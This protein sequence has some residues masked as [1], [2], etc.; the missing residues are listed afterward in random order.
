MTLHKSIRGL[1]S[2]IK[3][4]HWLVEFMAQNF[5]N[6]VAVSVL[7]KLKPGDVLLLPLGSLIKHFRLSLLTHN[8]YQACIM[9]NI[10]SYNQLYANLHCF[11]DF[12]DGL[13]L[14][15][16]VV[17]SPLE[18]IS[19]FEKIGVASPLSYMKFLNSD[20][21]KFKEKYSGIY[22]NFLRMLNGKGLNTLE[23]ANQLALNRIKKTWQGGGTIHLVKATDNELVDFF[24]DKAEVHQ[25]KINALAEHTILECENIFEESSVITFHIREQLENSPAK[26]YVVSEDAKVTQLIENKLARLNITTRGY[27]RNLSDTSPYALLKAIIDYGD[28]FKFRLV[29]LL[30]AYISRFKNVAA[31]SELEDRY[32]RKPYEI[33]SFAELLSIIGDHGL[34]LELIKLAELFSVIEEA[35]TFKDFTIGVFEVFNYLAAFELI[36]SAEADAL[37]QLKDKVLDAKFS[38]A[39]K[40]QFK[41]VLELLAKSQIITVP[42]I[43]EPN[44]E[45]I[46]FEQLAFYNPEVLV[47]AGSNTELIKEEAHKELLNSFANCLLTYAKFTTDEEKDPALFYPINNESKYH[48]WLMQLSSEP[49]SPSNR[50]EPDCALRPTKYS[51]SSVEQL[52][53]D[54][55]VFYAKY[56]LKL[57]E[58][59]EINLKPER[60]EFGLAMHYALSKLTMSEQ[61]DEQ[62]F[63]A[64]IAAEFNTFLAETHIKPKPYWEQKMLRIANELYK[65][66]VEN[67]CIEFVTEAYGEKALSIFDQPVVLNMR[68]DRIDN[69]VDGTKIIYD[70][71]TG[72]APTNVL[73]KSGKKPQLL[74]GAYVFGFTSTKLSYLSLLGKKEVVCPTNMRFELKSVEEGLNQLFTT[75]M[76]SKYYAQLHFDE[77]IPWA[78]RH[79]NRY[80]EWYS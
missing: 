61:N 34:R 75:Y 67:P 2:A 64:K 21:E 6:S 45:F 78:Y 74:I 37:V 16:I 32:L 27:T 11:C 41:R 19:C 73:V 8:D 59:E 72:A 44:V 1:L 40:E 55:Y 80:D 26:I 68:A 49:F 76:K 15:E 43:H 48:D 54:P 51:A 22:Q 24:L 33:D 13:D 3:L 71:K 18:M 58:L 60:R 52:M 30:R 70:Y 5:I 29:S 50:P 4:L 47:I 42:Q 25:P 66:F 36:D 69:S 38:F 56:I 9:P 7:A 77:F 20:P 17:A 53:N 57:R 14:S 23:Q 46:S 31:L 65:Y 62:K 12:C 63:K 28:D 10:F 35:K 79:L 39:S